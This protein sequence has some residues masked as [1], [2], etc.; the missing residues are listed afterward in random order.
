VV[1]RYLSTSNYGAWTYALAAV[2]FL[3][4]ITTFGLNRAISRFIPLH[5]ERREYPEFY[6]VL[7]LVMGALLT[8]G[9]LVIGVFYLLPE[10][11]S[12]LA[13]VSDPA[14]IQLMFVLILMVPF[15]TLDNVLLGVS[16]ALGDSRTIFVRRFLLHPGLRLAVAVILVA[17]GAGVTVLAIG[18]VL[19]ALIGVSY[20]AVGVV[21]AMGAEGL[22]RF[23]LVRGLRLP[24]RQVLTFTVPAM[25]ADWGAIFMAASGPLIL[26]YLADMS[27]VALYQVVVPL[28]AMNLLVSKSFAMLYEPSASRLIARGDAAGL[29]RLYWRSAV[30]VA[31]LTF[32]MFAVSFAAARPLVELF[33]GAR[34]ADAAPILSVL[35]LGQFVHGVVG[36]N[37]ETLRVGGH[38]KQLIGAN[39]AGLVTNIAL[40]IVLIPSMG[41]LGAAVGAAA[42]YVVYTILKQAALIITSDVATFD[43][44]YSA[45]FLAMAAGVVV[46]AGVRAASPS[47]WILLPT[48]ALVS[49]GVLA[50]ARLSLSISDTFPELGRWPLLRRVLG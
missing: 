13:G 20:Y 49:A 47:A 26:G 27:T 46:L 7:A 39:A 12:R 3:K 48:V 50:S 23:G 5:L 31:V 29:S 33:Y 6:G 2:T 30:W 25:A 4:G 10:S 44:A 32:P 43:L 45:P 14:P 21:R 38:L 8:L 37:A 16:A 40:S 17:L 42:G 35:A 19:A 15:E 41:A 34:Y 24:V 28:A 22:L 9:A 36:F 11:V 18:Y 1:V